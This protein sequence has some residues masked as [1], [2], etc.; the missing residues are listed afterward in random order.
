L[1]KLATAN[2]KKAF[3]PHGKSAAWAVT[4][5]LPIRSDPQHRATPFRTTGTI[6]GYGYPFASP[7]M[8]P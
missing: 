4:L 2:A 5:A 7:P 1:E 6:C 3:R 8:H